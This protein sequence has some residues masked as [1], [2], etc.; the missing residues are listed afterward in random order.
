VRFVGAADEPGA[1][2][3]ERLQ[4]AQTPGEEARDRVHRRIDDDFDVVAPPNAHL[5]LDRRDRIELVGWGEP[6]VEDDGGGHPVDTQD[7]SG[8]ARVGPGEQVPAAAPHRH[9][10]RVEFHQ[11]LLPHP[12]GHTH[13]A[14][15]RGRTD[16]D[17]GDL[18]IRRR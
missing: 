12:I 1:A 6:F 5:V 11:E 14:P 9:G 15:G 18:R 10:P 7:A 16:E 17:R 4:P 8:P 3:V 13:P 2:T